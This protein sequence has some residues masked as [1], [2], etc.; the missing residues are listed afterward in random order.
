[1]VVML[2][3]SACSLTRARSAAS[4]D[5]AAAARAS[6][7]VRRFALAVVHDSTGAELPL[8]WPAGARTGELVSSYPDPSRFEGGPTGFALLGGRS[9]LYDDALLALDR[10]RIGDREGAVR[11]LAA[12]AALQLPDGAWGFSVGIDDGFYD[13]GL[14]RSGNVAFVIYAFARYAARFGGE[15]EPWIPAAAL[16]GGSWLLEQRDDATGLLRAG[17]GRWTPGGA[18]L[19][20]TAAVDFAATEHQI[21]AFFALASLARIDPD[22]PWSRSALALEASVHRF[23][24]LEGEGRFAQGWRDG[25]PDR[26]SALDSSGSWGALFLLACGE[27]AKA[28]RALAWIDE[29]HAATGPGW[30]GY[31]PYASGPVTWFVEASAAI[32]LARHR[33]EPGEP[34]AAS[35]LSRLAALGRSRGWPLVYSTSWEPDFPLAPAAAPTLWFLLV[36][37]EVREAEAPFLWTECPGAM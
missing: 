21:D 8:S 10:I 23:L 19:E 29:V 15:D 34:R 1:M 13:A 3:S 31:K 12:L 7:D 30:S 25:A 35:G 33:L 36:H 26:Q 11:V 28:R 9:F 27:R 24:W 20:S 32:P 6:L 22:G 5:D 18:R 4:G 14:V 17:R 16:R 37:D 2:L